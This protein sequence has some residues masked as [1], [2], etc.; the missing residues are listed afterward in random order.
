MNS[1]R[2]YIT[3]PVTSQEINIPIEITEDFLGRSDSIELYED[4]VLG[5]IIGV[6]FDF[7]VG[8][9]SH[10]EYTNT[11]T[12]T[13]V[14][15]EFYFFN[16][17]PVTVTAST[18]NNWENSYI[19]EGFNTKELYYFANSFANS[20]FKLDFYDNPDEKNQ[21]NYFTVIIPT[22]QGFTTT[23]SISPYI[24]P[25][26]IKIPKYRLDFVGDK[27]GFF[28]Y[29]LS[30]P[31]FLSLTTFYM[32]VKFFDAKLGVFVRMMNEPQSNLPQAFQ[33]DSSKYFYNIVEINYE[34]KKYEIFDGRNPNTKVGTVSNPMKWYEYINPT[35]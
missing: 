7:E 19:P 27:E 17:N 24:P 22:Q 32:S 29:W 8:R 4:E 21:T 20:F 13:S 6:P 10:N 26:K 33:F 5:E 28:L 15:Y 12:R 11:D 23:A 14:N 9:Y 31:Q 18:I 16:G 35:I 30:V 3:L 25:V 34:T 2:Y 1:N